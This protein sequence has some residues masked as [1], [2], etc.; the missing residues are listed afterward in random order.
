MI[1]PLLIF[2]LLLIL[3]STA[4]ANVGLPMI[5]VYLPSAWIALIPVIILEDKI[6]GDQLNPKK[7]IVMMRKSLVASVLF[8]G[9]CLCLHGCGAVQMEKTDEV[10]K[11]AEAQKAGQ[12]SAKDPCEAKLA[13]LVQK[14]RQTM[15][16]VKD[17][18]GATKMEV[19][20]MW[21]MD[22]DGT[23]HIRVYD[24]A[25]RTIRDELRKP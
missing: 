7:G 15:K 5:A 2:F 23:V 20:P 18:C 8:V 6:R 16:T 14:S 24:A 11:S 22:Y 4:A 12:A 13:E 3:P 25:G 9:C 17:S 10:V 1:I 19:N 21:T